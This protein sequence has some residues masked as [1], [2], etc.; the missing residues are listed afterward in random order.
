MKI[1]LVFGDFWQIFREMA[2][3]YIKSRNEDRNF[4]SI[5]SDSQC[6]TFRE[7]N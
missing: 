7:I 3:I 5:D 6:M 2:E 4:V 1:W